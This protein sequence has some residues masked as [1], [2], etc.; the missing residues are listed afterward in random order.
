[1]LPYTIWYNIIVYICIIE[2][3]N[4]RPFS[5]AGD[6]AVKMLNVT[7]PTPQQLQAFKNEVGVLRWIY[8]QVLQS[9][10]TCNTSRLYL[11]SR[12]FWRSSTQC[13]CFVQL[14][15]SIGVKLILVSCI[16]IDTSI[17]TNNWY[18]H[19]VPASEPIRVPVSATNIRYWYLVWY[20]YQ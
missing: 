12:F 18:R 7:A 11:N 6:V 8:L 2:F 10:K 1:M 17:C 13:V 5:S 9:S 20:W 19:P 3:Y 15:F 14:Q 16:G 4:C